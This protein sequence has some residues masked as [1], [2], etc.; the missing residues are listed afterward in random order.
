MLEGGGWESDFRMP[1]AIRRALSVVSREAWPA[2]SWRSCALPQ[3]ASCLLTLYY[4][5]CQ[6]IRNPVGGRSRVSSA[7]SGRNIDTNRLWFETWDQSIPEE[8]A[9][10]VATLRA[11][12]QLGLVIHEPKVEIRTIIITANRT[13]RNTFSNQQ[14]L[15]THLRRSLGNEAVKPLRCRGVSDR[16]AI[17]IERLVERGNSIFV[18]N[19][20][21]V[22]RRIDK[23]RDTTEFLGGGERCVAA[24]VG[25]RD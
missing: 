5:L 2:R 15:P 16:Q 24:Q 22:N 19:A 3:P 17:S 13:Y 25:Q 20:R 18:G 11:L 8:E 7:R 6:S 12:S 1:P 4:V 10:G 14:H 9:R 21:V 23:G